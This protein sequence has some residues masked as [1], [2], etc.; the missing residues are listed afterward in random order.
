MDQPEWFF[1]DALLSSDEKYRYTL[2]RK[3]DRSS[4]SLPIVMLN[5]STADASIDDPTIKSC[6]RVARA[7]GWGGIFVMNLYAYRTTYP[8]ML[9]QEG[10]PEGPNNDKHLEAMLETCREQGVSIM[11]AWGKHA[12]KDRVNKFVQQAAGVDLLCW[13]Q[14][15]DGSPRHPLYAPGHARLIDFNLD[16][17]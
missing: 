16:M 14:N 3:W 8:Y 11:V 13:K 1:S 2:E 9:E 12:Q 10:Y 4:W 5:P 7:N 15:L 17:V 6:M